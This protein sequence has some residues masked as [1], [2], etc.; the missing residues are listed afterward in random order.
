MIRSRAKLDGT[1]ED[2]AAEYYGQQR[3]GSLIVSEREKSGDQADD[4]SSDSR[5][6]VVSRKECNGANQVCQPVGND[7][8]HQPAP[9]P[10]WRFRI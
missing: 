5:A 3:G 9:A 2:L 8:K 1:P 10:A 6:A 7:V 4:D